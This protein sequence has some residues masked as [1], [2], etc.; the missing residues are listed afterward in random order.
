[1]LPE[2]NIVHSFVCYDWQAH[3]DT[4]NYRCSRPESIATSAVTA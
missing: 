3:L 4:S 1:M 2:T